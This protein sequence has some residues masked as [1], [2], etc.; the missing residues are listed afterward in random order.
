VDVETLS[1][2]R[3]RLRIELPR[4]K[5]NSEIDRICRELRKEVSVPGFRRGRVPREIL[6]A[7]FEDHVK[8]TLIS[9]LLPSELQRIYREKDITPLSPPEVK[10]ELSELPLKGDQPWMIEVEVEVRPD[11]E[12]PPYD[13]IQIEKWRPDVPRETVDRYIESLREQHADYS[14]IQETRPVQ[15]GDF[16]KVDL[17]VSVPERG[18]FDAEE[19]DLIIQVG[20]GQLVKEVEEKLI[21]MTPG[22]TQKIEAAF[23]RDHYEPM[24]AGQNAVFEVTLK[25]I[26]E[27]RL[28]DL[29]DEFAKELNFESL[30]QMRSTIWNRLVE[31]EKMRITSQ[32]YEEVTRQIIEKTD[33][34]IPESIIEERLAEIIRDIRTG[35]YGS[36][37]DR[38]KLRDPTQ[39]EDFVNSL[40]Q[41][42]IFEIKKAWIFEEIAKK[43]QIE[44]SDAEV[45]QALRVEALRRNIDPQRY[46]SQIKSAGRF[47]S[48]KDLILNS[49]VCDFLIEN[50]SEK[51]SIII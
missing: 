13:Q 43:E 32:L 19:K 3:R 38:E 42:L 51:S 36:R 50:A 16:V 9:D 34:A 5:V 4:E 46:I 48:M 1:P 47:E 45:E 21:G 39:A 7:R 24:L 26:L 12:L 20:G 14:P 31:E 25:E 17:K 23:P 6:L 28:P 10:T 49:R 22:E 41:E 40:R 29:D 27:R 44:V 8:T 18:I 37:E 30:E 2:T 35:R 11:I 15:E 33:V